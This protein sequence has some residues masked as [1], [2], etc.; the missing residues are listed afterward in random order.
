MDKPRKPH[1]RNPRL[2]NLN[3]MFH[4]K[5]PKEDD[6][7]LTKTLLAQAR[8]SGVLNLSNRGLAFGE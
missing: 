6:K 2:Q 8:K 4:F 1:S 3:P 5:E 7:V